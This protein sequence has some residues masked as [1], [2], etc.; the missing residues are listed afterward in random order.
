MLIFKR[1][2]KLFDEISTAVRNKKDEQCCE[3]AAVGR[4]IS[5]LFEVPKTAEA[6]VN[7]GFFKH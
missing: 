5:S 6:Y 4:T 7:L 2:I 1:D 3:A